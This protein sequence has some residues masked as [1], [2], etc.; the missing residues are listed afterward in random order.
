MNFIA[1][2]SIC[3]CYLFGTKKQLIFCFCLYMDPFLQTQGFLAGSSWNTLSFIFIKIENDSIQ[4]EN[5]GYRV[6][7]RL[8]SP[9]LAQGPNS[10]E[11]LC[12]P[13]LYN[14][15]SSVSVSLSIIQY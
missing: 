4:S 2:G 11:L 8:G 1:A 14:I 15:Y 12:V 6:G 10:S 3:Y 7:Y 5:S 9:R 13:L